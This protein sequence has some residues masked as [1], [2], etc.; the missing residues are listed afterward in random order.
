MIGVFG[1]LLR[2]SFRNRLTR[3]IRRLREPRYL[4][5]FAVSILW[6]WNFVFRPIFFG[7]RHFR[8]A[9]MDMLPPDWREAFTFVI[10]LVCVRVV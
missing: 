10:G 7:N 5:P 4:V 3:R 8:V 9:G 1:Y 2:T 6:F